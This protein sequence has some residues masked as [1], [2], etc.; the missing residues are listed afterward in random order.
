ME[1]LTLGVLVSLLNIIQRAS[2][3]ECYHC[4]NSTSWESC[5]EN[6][7]EVTCPENYKRCFK[8]TITTQNDLKNI[9]SSV[10]ARGCAD[11]CDATGILHCDKHVICDAYCCTADLCNMSPSMVPSKI[12]LIFMAALLPHTLAYK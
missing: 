1:Y 8:A 3:L 4:Q 5:D 7:K 9:S 12:L 2:G 6:L 10:F 11:R